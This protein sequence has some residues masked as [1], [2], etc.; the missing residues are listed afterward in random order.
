MGGNKPEA[1][2]RNSE[3]ISPGRAAQPAN[4]A[5]W[6]LSVLW[7]ITLITSHYFADHGRVWAVAL[8]PLCPSGPAST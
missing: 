7:L 2:S 1:P 4:L 5:A 6:G 8:P 3:P